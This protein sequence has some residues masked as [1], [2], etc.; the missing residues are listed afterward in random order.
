LFDLSASKS[1]NFDEIRESAFQVK[2]VCRSG[3]CSRPSQ[4][5]QNGRGHESVVTRTRLKPDTEPLLNHDMYGIC[6][7]ANIGPN[8]WSKSLINNIFAFMVHCTANA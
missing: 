3:V 4:G 6:S 5:G 1:P 8:I 2:V 7:P